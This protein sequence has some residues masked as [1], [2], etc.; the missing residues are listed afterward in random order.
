MLRSKMWATSCIELAGWVRRLSYDKFKP[1]VSAAGFFIKVLVE[2]ISA[3][4]AN[5]RTSAKLARLSNVSRFRWN[6]KH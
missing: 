1:A 4:P 6:D 3:N 5:A 2:I